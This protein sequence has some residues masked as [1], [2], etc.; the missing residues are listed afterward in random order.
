MKQLIKKPVFQL[1]VILAAVSLPA[2]AAA[3][4]F[5]AEIMAIRGEAFQ[6]PSGLSRISAKI[7]ALVSPGDSIETG[8]ASFVDLGFD[9]NWKNVTRI[10]EKS[11]VK[12]TDIY[13]TSLSLVSGDVLAKLDALPKDS[14]FEIKTPT[15]VIGI[16]GSICAVEYKDG[17][18]M[19]YNPHEHA[20]SVAPPAEGSALDP[21]KIQSVG[22]NQ[23]ATVGANL[24]VVVQNMTPAEV[25]RQTKAVADIS[26]SVSGSKPSKQLEKIAEISASYQAMLDKKIPTQF[27]TRLLDSDLDENEAP[28]LVQRAGAGGSGGEGSSGS[29]DGGGSDGSGSL[30]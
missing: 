15:A 18:T 6:L 10:G 26:A 13:P 9:R 12:I 1:F 19:V 14:T 23:K 5:R 27:D 11:S 7:A 29:G 22:Q 20:I 25:A 17:T 8:A 28:H 30:P 24:Q 21:S 2:L 16:R 4:V 3:G